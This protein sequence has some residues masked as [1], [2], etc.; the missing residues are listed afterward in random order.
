MYLFILQIVWIMIKMTCH[1]TIAFWIVGAQLG[2][3][4]YLVFMTIALS[5]FSYGNYIHFNYIFK[6]NSGLN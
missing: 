6:A 1:C 3:M 2:F 4:E 5:A